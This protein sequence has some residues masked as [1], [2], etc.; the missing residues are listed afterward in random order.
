MSTNKFLK[1]SIPFLASLLLV[2]CQSQDFSKIKT[3]FSQIKKAPSAI[4]SMGKRSISPENEYTSG[5]VVDIPV[6]LEDILGSSL[7]TENQGTDF[8]SSIKYALDTDPE[9]VS[10][11][12]ILK[13]RLLV[14]IAEAQRDFQVGTTLY[15]GI[16][17]VTDTLR[18]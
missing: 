5:T 2:S 16:E 9:I 4:L 14:G 17:D 10:N 6:P 8:L 12:V 3:N 7:A 1:V 15:G 18:V 11:G 13:Q